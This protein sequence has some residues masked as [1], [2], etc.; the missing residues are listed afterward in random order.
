[1]LPSLFYD[2]YTMLESNIPGTR[3][4][5]KINYISKP[6]IIPQKHNYLC[7]LHRHANGNALPKKTL[8]F[9]DTRHK[10]SVLLAMST[11]LQQESS[12]LL[13]KIEKKKSW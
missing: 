6:P 1:M 5:R 10:I 12:K 7:P 4:T 3:F 9:K 8:N 2:H 11:N 13:K